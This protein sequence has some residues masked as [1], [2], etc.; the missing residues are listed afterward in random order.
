MLTIVL[1]VDWWV[2]KHCKWQINS[3][4]WKKPHASKS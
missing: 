4:R 2:H 3:S 1:V